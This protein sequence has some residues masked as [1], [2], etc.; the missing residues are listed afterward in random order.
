MMIASSTTR[1]IAST[2]ASKVKRLIEKPK[3]SIMVK[4]P[5]SDKGMATV[6]ITTERTEPRNAKTTRITITSA[7]SSVR[8]TS[9]IALFTNSVES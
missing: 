2:I 3:I 1:P 7:S 9:L 8:M 4:V 5:T 6:G